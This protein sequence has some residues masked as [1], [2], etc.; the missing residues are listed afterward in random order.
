MVLSESY[1]LHRENCVKVLD[2]GIAKLTE[3][4]ATDPDAPTKPLINTNQGVVLGTVS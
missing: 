1:A 2:F 3:T 4:Q